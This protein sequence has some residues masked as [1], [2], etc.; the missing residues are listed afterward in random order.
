MKTVDLVYNGPSAVIVP[1]AGLTVEPGTT[2]PIPVELAASLL[3]R[4][5]WSKAEKAPKEGESK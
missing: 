5:S 1:D 3:S 2:A 4:S